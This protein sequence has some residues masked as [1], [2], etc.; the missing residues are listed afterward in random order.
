MAASSC[1]GKVQERAA[2]A[3]QVAMQGAVELRFRELVHVAASTLVARFMIHNSSTAD[4]AL[5]ARTSISLLPAALRLVAMQENGIVQ[6]ALTNMD[7]VYGE[8]PPPPPVRAEG[9]RSPDWCRTSLPG[10]LVT[11]TRRRLVKDLPRLMGLLQRGDVDRAVETV[12]AQAARPLAAM[13]RS[14]DHRLAILR[15]ALLSFDGDDADDAS[16]WHCVCK[17]CLRL[18]LDE[19][20]DRAWQAWLGRQAATRPLS[21]AVLANTVQTLSNSCSVIGRTLTG[22]Q[23]ASLVDQIQGDLL[24]APSEATAEEP[25]SATR[26]FMQEMERLQAETAA[27]RAPATTST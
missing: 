16:G 22:T 1:G 27:A 3:R 12:L 4:G 21:M 8:T 9:K 6:A 20:L 25:P 11:L 17:W 10:D 26:S 15:D 23:I 19:R 7:L 5:A 14:D 18:R 24:S 13:L 2:A